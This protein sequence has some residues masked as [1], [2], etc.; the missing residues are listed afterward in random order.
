MGTPKWEQ[1]VPT[2]GEGRQKETRLIG[3][4]GGNKVA[5][6]KKRH[7]EVT[8]IFGDPGPLGP[9]SVFPAFPGPPWAFL[10]LLQKQRRNR[11]FFAD[12]DNFGQPSVQL[13]M[14]PVPNR[15]N[16]IQAPG[17]PHTRFPGGG[18]VQGKQL[19]SHYV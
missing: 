13:P 14:A 12:F 5:Y 17:L 10:T 8:D 6:V 1:I 9:T 19:Q 2:S 16:G 7:P 4:L 18:G 11:T 3:P 15:K